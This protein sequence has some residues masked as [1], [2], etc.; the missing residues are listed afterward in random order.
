MLM[1]FDGYG[2][3]EACAVERLDS[4]ESDAGTT[5]CALDAIARE[6]R[7]WSPGK[8]SLR[9]AVTRAMRSS[10]EPYAADDN[11]EDIRR[12]ALAVA[13]VP[14]GL[15]CASGNEHLALRH[16]DITPLWREFDAVVRRYLAAKLFA[17]WWPYL[18]LDLVAVV[19]AIRVHAAVL[20]V[21]LGRRLLRGET[22][23]CA[24]REAIRD[25]DLLMVHLSDSRALAR[26]I[27]QS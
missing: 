8:E 12:H 15:E 6:I 22:G 25:T 7:E 9:E 27:A 11:E 23:A 17:S 14:H 21:S 24:M 10:S 26:L 18:G 4:A 13:S 19:F 5:L 16:P 1:D 20:R 3:W 2:A